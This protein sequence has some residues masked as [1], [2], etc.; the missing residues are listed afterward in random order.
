MNFILDLIIVAIIAVAVL[1]TVKRGFVRSAVELAGFILAVIL[2]FNLGPALAET[3][4]ENIIKEPVAKTVENSLDSAVSE[5]VGSL[6]DKVWS[7]M[8][9]FITENAEKFGIS[10]DTMNSSLNSVTS[11]NT[12]DI[13]LELTD[14][15]V[16]PIAVAGLKVVFGFLIFIIVAIL[17]KLLAKPINKLFSISFAGTINRLL[18]AVLGLGKGLIYSVIFCAIISIIVVFTDSGFLFFTK[19]NIES[20]MLF[21]WLCDLNPIY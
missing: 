9:R 14:N 10:R 5:Q 19:E 1:L 16:K 15:I 6:S 3:T 12:V 17:A 8:P 4:Y 13:A 7:G 18:G 20:S 2:A 21:K 11:D